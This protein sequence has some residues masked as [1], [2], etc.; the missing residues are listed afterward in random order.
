[1]KS[2]AAHLLALDKANSPF[3][4]MRYRL[5]GETKWH[6]K[7]LKVRDKQVAERK[8]AE[9][10]KEEEREAGGVIPSKALRK[11]AAVSLEELV[12]E[13]SADLLGQKRN[14]KYVVN[15]RRQILV[16][17]RDCCWT[18]VGDISSEDFMKW[19]AANSSKSARTLN[20]YLASLKAFLN[21]M[22]ASDRL[23]RNPLE[24]VKKAKE[25]GHE[26]RERR[27]ATDDE[28]KAILAEAPASR[29]LV[30]MIAVHTGLRRNEIKEL[31]RRYYRSL[32]RCDQCP[33]S[34]PS[35]PHT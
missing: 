20:L 26:R 1:M 24:K 25:A 23:P 12:G 29:R 4:Q 31:T 21:W 7:S 15:E 17:A 18:R 30:Y 34:I 10:I 32:S 14:D 3:Y 13:Y 8:V 19:R 35:Q 5:P 2:V 6:Q 11:S 16:P 9:F 27:A 33:A 28:I 22:V